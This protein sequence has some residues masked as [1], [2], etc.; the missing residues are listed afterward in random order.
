MTV[1]VFLE[2]IHLAMGCSHRN[3][4]MSKRS[5]VHTAV[6]IVMLLF[7]TLKILGFNYVYFAVYV[8]FCIILEKEKHCFL[9]TAQREHEQQITNQ[10]IWVVTI[11]W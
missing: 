7:L 5:C 6:L 2:K 10:N 3:L 8:C 9:H 1:G 4:F 11:H